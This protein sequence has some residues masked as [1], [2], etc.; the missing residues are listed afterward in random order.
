MSSI[1]TMVWVFLTTGFT[2]G[3][4]HCIGMCGPIV[5][6][7]SLQ[8]KDGNTLWPHVLYNTGRVTTY[9]LLGG[10]MGVTG[11][12][13]MV[14]SGIAGIQKGVLVFAGLLI[15]FMGILMTGWLKKFSCFSEGSGLQT[16]FSK[17][18]SKLVQSKSTLAYFP[19]GLLL[20]L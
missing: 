6:S 19:V 15:I 5:I 11:S 10:V 20:G 7:M 4:G 17:T 14:T 2:V 16:F 3:F 8:M 12:F 1:D 13:A 9:A 18:F